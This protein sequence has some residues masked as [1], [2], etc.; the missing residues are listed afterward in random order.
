HYSADVSRARDDKLDEDRSINATLT[1]TRGSVKQEPLLQADEIAAVG[2]NSSVPAAVASPCGRRMCR[3]VEENDPGSTA[4]AEFESAGIYPE[5]DT[6]PSS[7]SGLLRDTA[8]YVSPGM[9]R[10]PVSLEIYNSFQTLHSPL[11]SDNVSWNRREIKGLD[12]AAV[13][14]D[15]ND[16]VCVRTSK[17]ISSC[18][19]I[20][21]AEKV[22]PVKPKG[23]RTKEAVGSF[24]QSVEPTEDLEPAALVEAIDA[25]ST[26]DRKDKRR[27]EISITGNRDDKMRNIDLDRFAKTD[28]QEGCESH[29]CLAERNT[30]LIL[31]AKQKTPTNETAIKLKE[32]ASR[33]FSCAQLVT[34]LT[35][36][37]SPVVSKSLA[38]LHESFRRATS[39][40]PVSPAPGLMTFLSSR[41]THESLE[42]FDHDEDFNANRPLQGNSRKDSATTTNVNNKQQQQER[43]QS[44]ITDSQEGETPSSS[45][46]SSFEIA[47]PSPLQAPLT[48]LSRLSFDATTGD[49]C[50]GDRNGNRGLHNLKK[51]DLDPAISRGFAKFTALCKGH[52]CRKLLASSRVQMLIRDIV[53]MVH[54]ALG[55]HGPPF[56]FVKTTGDRNAVSELEE[57][58]DL[59]QNY[60]DVLL[61][62]RILL[63]LE[64]SCRELHRLFFDITPGERVGLIRERRVVGEDVKGIRPA[65]PKRL[66]F[67]T[68]KRRQRKLIEE[69]HETLCFSFP[70]FLMI[71][72]FDNFALL[73]YNDLIYGDDCGKSMRYN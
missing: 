19:Y 8:S 27:Q 57:E 24:S 12:K 61:H 32:L 67:A 13:I 9:V 4:V 38:S 43:E 37:S 35:P 49:I 7:K 30:Y 46:V 65:P 42:P 11:R 55:L 41:H 16:D 26:L 31:Q 40:T 34:L 3:Q 59:G 44:Q 28:G 58:L 33:L 2:S 66:T 15:G 69:E 73:D 50:W 68:L 56:H 60:Q 64:E 70:E 36:R 62:E 39:L 51:A 29:K 54:L 63:G 17:N 53:D 14:Y 20:S 6:Q 25:Q 47:E 5:R 71:S 1:T 72:L 10:R 22:N 48:P 45:L 52:L 23:E 21:A 18:R